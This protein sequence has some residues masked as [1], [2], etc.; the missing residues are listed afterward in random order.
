MVSNPYSVRTHSFSDSKQHE[1]HSPCFTAA[2]SLAP[3]RTELAFRTLDFPTGA[4]HGEANFFLPSDKYYKALAALQEVCEELCRDTGK[5]NKE[6][7]KLLRTALNAFQTADFEEFAPPPEHAP[8][9]IRLDMIQRDKPA[10]DSRIEHTLHHAEKEAMDKAAL[11]KKRLE[12][13]KAARMQQ[14]AALEKKKLEELVKQQAAQERAERESDWDHNRTENG[15]TEDEVDAQEESGDDGASN[16]GESDDKQAIAVE[17]I[18]KLYDAAKDKKI[19]RNNDPF[20]KMG[21]VLATYK[22]YQDE[23]EKP[24]STNTNL[25]IV[26]GYYEDA[27][28]VL[29]NHLET[30]KNA[31]LIQLFK[32]DAANDMKLAVDVACESF[33]QED[34]EEQELDQI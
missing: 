33:P 10:H 29:Q 21:K 7:K 9:H 20:Q 30:T 23:R 13:D 2:P 4:L 19:H 8:V 24:A 15:E 32:A 6:E 12:R 14:K 27:M 5:K 22:A 28:I 31:V 18:Q 16:G 17:S 26:F 11:E 1:T 34:E 3:L 25:N